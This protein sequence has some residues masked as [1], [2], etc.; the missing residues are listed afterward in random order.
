MADDIGDAVNRRIDGTEP[1][2]LGAIT[3]RVSLEGYDPEPWLYA[4]LH[5]G[6]PEHLLSE[7]DQTRRAKYREQVR[8]DHPEYAAALVA[9]RPSVIP[10]NGRDYPVIYGRSA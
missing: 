5:T 7:R 1:D 2:P 3:S 8:A 10:F 4:P 6:L 9:D